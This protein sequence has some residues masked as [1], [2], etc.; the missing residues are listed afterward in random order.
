MSARESGRQSWR[1]RGLAEWDDLPIH[2]SADVLARIS[3][4]TWNWM[5]RWYFN[6]RDAD[7]ALVA[8][9]GSG[10]FPNTGV[11]ESYF[12]YLEDNTQVNVRA[13][14]HM[15]SRGPSMDSQ[16]FSARI[17]EPMRS[18]KIGL[19][20]PQAKLD[21]GFRA[22]T[23][24]FH[25]RPFWQGPDREGGEL[26]QWQHFIQLGELSGSLRTSSTEL[27][28]AGM[29]GVRDRSWGVRSRRP[30]LHN[31]YVFDFGGEHFTMVHQ[32]RA[33]G[34]VLVSEAA[35]FNDAGDYLSLVVDEHDLRFDPHSR[36]VLEGD[37]RLH[38][39]HGEPV[40]LRFERSGAGLRGLGA[41]YDVNQGRPREGGPAAQNERWDL[42][43]PD[44][45]SRIGL[46]TIDVP[47]RAALV[48]D[49]TELS[50]SGIAETAVG[51]S[52]HRYGSQVRG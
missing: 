4:Q 27:D 5:D 15:T 25:Y 29:S 52:H 17:E 31:W 9:L 35:L 26:D 21:L 39:A 23:T 22:R 43:D 14:D 51:R 49:G 12:C 18:W 37:W 30:R 50:G 13:W 6:I 44:T 19:D 1:T 10:Y 34:S 33:D 8:I 24:P 7:G 48:V 45:V 28:L 41:G 32:E 42:D 40:R 11:L 20:S 3:D 2:Q 36:E 46:G 16:G 47:A 38:D